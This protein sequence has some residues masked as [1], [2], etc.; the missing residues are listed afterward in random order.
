MLDAL[1]LPHYQL[2][3]AYHEGGGFLVS[4]LEALGFTLLG[5]SILVVKLV[6]IGFAV[7]TLVAGA[8][9]LADHV[10]ERA[11]LVFAA[12]FALAPESFQR[13]SLL[14][15][16]THVEASLF[17]LLA[18]HFTART[19]NADKQAWKHAPIWLGVCGGFGCYVGLQMPP[20]LFVCGVAI[21]VN[22]RGRALAGVVARALIGF[23]IGALPL[24]WMMSHV[25]FDGIL[26]HRDTSKG[27]GFFES[28]PLA[29]TSV[30]GSRDPLV[31][32]HAIGF[33]VVIVWGL[34]Q[35][36]TRLQWILIAYLL[37]F[38]I[39]WGLSGLAKKYGAADPGA[40]FEM[41][42]IFPP[43]IVVTLLAACGID[44][45][46]SLGGV[47]R[48]VAL[49]TG[50][51]A[52]VAGV[53]GT[54]ALASAGSPGSPVENAR[55]LFTARGYSYQ[56]YFVQLEYHFEGTRAHKASVML[57]SQDDPALLVPDVANAIYGQQGYTSSAATTGRLIEDILP[58]LA[59]VFGPHRDLALLGV[60]ATVNGFWNYDVPAAFVKLE[61]LPADVREPLAEGLG[62]NGLGPRFLPE[63][64]PAL[65][66]VVPPE[67]WHDAWWRGVGWRIHQTFR[68]R[69]DRARGVIAQLPERDR[70]PASI[71][72]ERALELDRIR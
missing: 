63:K 42:R 49:A 18:F 59:D 45:L 3:F 2:N 69:P 57:R 62:R 19:L 66:A 33:V 6:A 41:L 71:G 7:A 52:L 34:A 23:V 32:L 30:L 40:F 48:V 9:M 15:L 4:H 10:S 37:V 47:K 5:P 38:M 11:A 25:G 64:L 68:W 44:T 39:G 31:W 36:R 61:S 67:P 21:L 24:W 65:F 55:T 72:Y 14:S 1:G 28:L 56:E 29:F 50:V 13:V 60:G 51:I 54:V 20:A 46:W 35:R 43:W 26:V 17:I 70:V 58:E 27:P 12:L 8:W 22:L 53:R 16:G